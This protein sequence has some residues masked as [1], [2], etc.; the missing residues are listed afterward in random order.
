MYGLEIIGT[1]G[2]RISNRIIEMTLQAGQE[3]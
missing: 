3:L 2:I 1:M